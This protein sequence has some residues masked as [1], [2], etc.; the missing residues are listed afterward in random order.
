MKNV[1]VV[2]NGAR[3]PTWY[4]L[5]LIFFD[6]FS[7]LFFIRRGANILPEILYYL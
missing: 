5:T 7:F 1:Y 2:D 6:F 3:L 4:L